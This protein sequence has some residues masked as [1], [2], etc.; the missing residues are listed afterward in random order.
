MLSE[1]EHLVYYYSKDLESL[2]ALKNNLGNLPGIGIDIKHADASGDQVIAK[3]QI[4]S[5]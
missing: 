4:K 1:S 5:R 2:E 3:I